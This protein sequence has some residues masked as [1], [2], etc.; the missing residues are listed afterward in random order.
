M[1][2]RI[3]FVRIIF[4]GVF[5]EHF[6]SGQPQKIPSNFE[7]QKYFEQDNC[8]NNLCISQI[9][10]ISSHTVYAAVDDLPHYE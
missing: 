1:K 8:I 10:L 2:T 3:I 4:K 5:R 7:N 9:R 6:L